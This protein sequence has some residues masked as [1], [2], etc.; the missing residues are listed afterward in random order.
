MSHMTTQE[1][2]IT[3][4][5]D[6]EPATDLRQDAIAKIVAETGVS[7]GE[8]ERTLDWI[9]DLTEEVRSYYSGR[10]VILFQEGLAPPFRI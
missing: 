8:A 7:V 1:Q 5:T 2:Q 4:A 3:A 6:P 10:W 9:V